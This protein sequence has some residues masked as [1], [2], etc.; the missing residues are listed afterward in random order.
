M[1]VTPAP[2]P[3]P[4]RPRPAATTT[5]AGAGAVAGSRAGRLRNGELR[6]Q[7]AAYLAAHPGTYTAGQ[8][9]RGLSG[10][11][12]GAV[13]N[14]LQAL[15]ARGEAAPAT[16]APARYTATPTTAAAALPTAATTT[17]TTSTATTAPHRRP[18]R[19]RR[20]RT[21]CAVTDHDR[22][23]LG[24]VGRAGNGCGEWGGV[25]AGA[26]PGRAAVSPAAGVGD[27]GCDRA[28]Q[29]AHGRGARPAVWATRHRQDLGR[30]G[31]LRRSDHR[32][33]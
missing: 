24:R 31:R 32:A 25:G 18:R 13:A 27:P 17:V 12:S 15:V 4:H 1:N 28:A 10:R 5:T 29:A 22:G 21:A 33:R 11:S 2:K 14:A 7:V 26:S 6:R 16:T 8:I 19:R 9:A 30:R 3:P 20:A 23:R